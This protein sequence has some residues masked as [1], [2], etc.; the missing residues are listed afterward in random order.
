MSYE[1]LELIMENTQENRIITGKRRKKQTK[2]F[3]DEK[4][5]NG[6][7]DQYERSSGF[8]RNN[9]F[10]RKSENTILG[11]QEDSIY[12][13]AKQRENGYEINEFVVEDEYE[14]SYDGE[15]SYEEES[16]DEDYYLEEESYYLEEESKYD[17]DLEET[18]E[19]E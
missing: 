17:S 15:S 11:K 19:D 16:S 10:G 2:F 14:S 6:R 12:K 18:K 9:W 5:V 7:Y 4:F 3:S 8:E 13:C 1:D